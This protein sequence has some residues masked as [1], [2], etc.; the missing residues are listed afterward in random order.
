MKIALIVALTL[1]TGPALASDWSR[2]R[3]PNGTGVAESTDLPIRFDLEHNLVWSTPLA[4]GYSSP[5]IAKDRIFL[6]GEADGAL[7]T[8][9][10]DRNTGAL[11]WQREAP[12]SRREK[13]DGRNNPA[14]PTPV[15]DGVGVYVFFPDH[16]LLGYSVK[17]DP[18]W[19][20]P[21]G[22]FD[23]IYGMGASPIL[24]DDRV[25]LVCDQSTDSFMLAVDKTTGAESWRVSRP[26]ARSGHSTPVV[27]Q[28]AEGPK[29]L[30]VPGS[31]L[32]TAYS[33]ETGEKLWWV[34]GLS[35]EMKS[36]PVLDG[37]VVYVN[38]YGSPLNQPG[39][40]VEVP[41]WSDVVEQ[42][43]ADGDGRL[44]E[45]ELPDERSRSWFGFV[46][47]NGDAALDAQDWNF[48]QAALATTNGVLAISVGGH[49]DRTQENV[50]WTYH[51]AVPQLPSPL[52]YGEVLYMV[53]DGGI[54]TALDPKTGEQLKQA[55]LK[56]ALGNYYASPVAA[57]GKVFMI[58]ED[59][60]VAVVAPDGALS[61]LAVN[62][63]GDSV[64][65]T[66]AISDGR[67]YIRTQSGLHCFGKPRS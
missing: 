58:T 59:G 19:D 41:D 12:R 43:D 67:I 55:R 63:L 21:L 17:G 11:L 3:G 26:E 1:L 28:P 66:P 39:R 38:G 57:D 24:V 52:L 6:T 8:Y 20:V 40:K 4:A 7:Y 33:V 2:F 61:I 5:V 30:L 53:N 13:I 45:A 46:D 48:Y 36:T 35:F 27:Y 14:S 22:P 23:N 29:Q 34:G 51:R 18:L 37:D 32:M 16:G 25:I 56:G 64:Y 65:A 50:R 42:Q 44:A 49:G 47:L 62:D 54:V 10:L 60:K 9:A 15:T 31:F